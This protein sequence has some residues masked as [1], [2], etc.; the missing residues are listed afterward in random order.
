M[1]GIF[2]ILDG[3][4]DLPTPLLAQKTP[5][6]T[7][8]TPNLNQIAR[9]S[10]LDYCFTVKDGLAPQSHNSVLS[11][12]GYDPTLIPR[13]PLEAMG[14]GIS[15][16]KGDL[17]LRTNFATINNLK[18]QNILDKR[19]GRT[20]TTSEAKTLAKAINKEVKLSYPF[21][22]HSTIQHRGVLVFR[23]GFSDNLTNADPYYGKG[24]VIANTNNK[25]NFSKPLDDEEDSKLSSELLNTFI[26]KSHEVLDKHPINI[27]RVKMGLYIANIILCRE[28]G[29]SPIKLKKQ[30]GKWMSLGYMPLEIGIGKAA[31]MDVYKFKYPKQKGIDVYPTLHAGL[32]L[33]IKNS[34]KM[35]KKYHKKYDYFYIHF[36]EPDIPGHDNKPLEKV[37]MIETLDEK[38]FSFLK[39]FIKDK[40][41]IITADHTT[42]CR[43]KAHTADPVPV[44]AYPS[45]G[46]KKLNPQRRFTEAFGKEGKKIVGRKLLETYFFN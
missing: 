13:G 45:T 30:R 24:I 11:L 34:I 8:K 38:F 3:V 4:A 36:K 16:K 5:L 31:G 18:D 28:P 27:Q 9:K 12:L 23:G 17:S 42:A 25:L 7:A 19:V 41:L 22:F 37:K 44:L 2:I 40:K 46:S 20:L 6:E 39:N 35:L 33:A 26:R 1:K 43:L 10:S 21:E 32:N 29:N 15:L 14:S